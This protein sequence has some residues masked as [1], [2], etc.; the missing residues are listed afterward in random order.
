VNDTES[1]RL[2]EDGVISFEQAEGISGERHRLPDWAGPRTVEWLGYFAGLALFVAT[3][4]VMLD[5]MYSGFDFGALSGLDP[6]NTFGLLGL[7]AALSRPDNIPGGIVALIGAL[8]LFGIGWRFSRGGG[9][10]GRTAGFDLFLGF[11]LASMAT[12]LLLTDLDIGDFTPLVLV[13]PIVVFAVFVWRTQPSL[14]TQV[15]LFLMV[16]QVVNAF[17]VLVQATDLDNPGVGWLPL[18]IQLAVGFLWIA[19]GSAGAVRPRNTAF[20]L[21][22][23]YAWTAAIDLFG[24]GDGWI[25]VSILVTLLFYWM[26]VS[27]R[28]SVL[29]AFGAVSTLFLVLQVMTVVYDDMP[30][31]RT[32]EF[33]YG[34]PAIAAALA[35]L[36]LISG[37]AQT[38]AM[39]AAPPSEE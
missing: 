33:W 5:V 26:G 37:G 9:A 21:G 32:F 4:L 24:S 23:F 35:A 10:A 36:W 13:I 16:T 22:A 29:A 30:S 19:L 27:R 28:S 1:K 12:D 8:A 20:V 38:P 3:F 6:T 7:M 11:V 25:V 39:A 34:I 15:A 14:L 2:V 31:L 17:L 18:L